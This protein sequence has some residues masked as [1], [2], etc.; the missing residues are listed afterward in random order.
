MSPRPRSHPKPKRPE[1]DSDM[2]I[3]AGFKFA[4]GV[5][6]CADTQHSAAGWMK[7]DASKI[8]P[9]DLRN[10]GGGQLAFALS[11]TNVPYAHMAIDHC[12]RAIVSMKPKERTTGGMYLKLLE[13]LEEFYQAHVYPHPSFR[14]DGVPGFNLLAAVRS[15]VDKT[16]NLYSADTTALN[17]VQ[18]YD[19]IGSGGFL[20]H[21]LVPRIFWHDKMA[22]KD[23]ANVAIHILRETKSYVEGCGGNSEFLALHKDG[24]F[25]RVENF[26]ISSGEHI[27]S[28]FMQAIRRLFIVAADLDTTPERMNQ[29]YAMLRTTI[30]AYRR[31]KISE[32]DRLEGFFKAL[33]DT[34]VLADNVTL[35]LAASQNPEA[36]K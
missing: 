30:D 13:T 4:D 14:E 22:L 29:E 6:L 19:C 24:K 27:S 25:G 9:F 18:K 21:Y 35:N 31:M 7:L 28:G 12:V 34:M 26:D 20:A 2:T 5:L 32:R 15:D 16:L 36:E 3:A 1:S 17:E 8:K 23:A 33:S 10:R 11:A